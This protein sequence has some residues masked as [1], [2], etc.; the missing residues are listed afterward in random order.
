MVRHW[1]RCLMTLYHA[2][3]CLALSGLEVPHELFNCLFISCTCSP[4]PEGFCRVI[5]LAA[6]L[7]KKGVHGLQ[8]KWFAAITVLDFRGRLHIL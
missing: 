7:S 6:H 2:A 5:A 3:H 4:A 8:Q 1:Q